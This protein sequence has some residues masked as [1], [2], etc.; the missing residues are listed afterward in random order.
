VRLNIP[1]TSHRS[2]GVFLH[3]KI[4]ATSL[5]T[6]PREAQEAAQAASQP[7]PKTLFEKGRLRVTRNFRPAAGSAPNSVDAWVEA[8]PKKHREEYRVAG[9]TIKA[10]QRGDTTDVTIN[11]KHI[12]HLPTLPSSVENLRLVGMQGL[13]CPP[14]TSQCQNLLSYEARECPWLELSVGHLMRLRS[15]DISESEQ[16]KHLRG[17]HHCPRLEVIKASYCR[18]LTS[19]RLAAEQTIKVLDLDGCTAMDGFP[20]AIEFSSLIHLHMRGVPIQN[21][22]EALI[23]AFVQS[24]LRAMGAVSADESDTCLQSARLHIDQ[25]PAADQASLRKCQATIRVSNN[26]SYCLDLT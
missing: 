25:L 10:C 17:T 21:L 5:Q 19:I 3:P 20:R 14:D 22:P 24:S 1:Y 6:H 23:H 15:L 2:I 16:L 8:A 12:T 26:P 7:H 9:E 18:G 11:G 13:K 4:D